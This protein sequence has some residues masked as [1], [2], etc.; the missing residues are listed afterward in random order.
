MARLHWIRTASIV[1]LLFFTV[2]VAVVSTAPPAH[3]AQLPPD[4][5]VQANDGWFHSSLSVH[6]VVSGAS[7][8]A[9]V[10]AQ[11]WVDKYSNNEVGWDT[12]Y[13]LTCTAFKNNGG[14]AY[15]SN[16]YI[17]SAFNQ[18]HGLKVTIGVF[19]SSRSQRWD[20]EVTRAGPSSICKIYSGV[21]Y[22]MLTRPAGYVDSYLWT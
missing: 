7:V 14:Y 9:Q 20:V 3:A 21:C 17:V 5:Y 2:M 6:Y 1:G 4:Q 13:I 22:Q 12:D 19:N 15:S 11:C 10:T 16:E 8:T 18:Q